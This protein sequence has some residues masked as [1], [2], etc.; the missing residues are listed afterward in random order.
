M[1][2]HNADE[3]G[4]V[5]ARKVIAR[6]HSPADTMAVQSLTVKK[7]SYGEKLKYL[8]KAKEFAANK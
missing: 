4:K 3:I 7:A 8:A 5:L 6:A 1:A 2:K